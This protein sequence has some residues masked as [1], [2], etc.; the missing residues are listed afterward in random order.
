MIENINPTDK[1]VVDVSMYQI[2]INASKLQSLR[3]EVATKYNVPI[4]N[5]YINPK[6]I[7][8]DE[9]G[10]PVSLTSDIITSI[11][12]PKF[13][14]NLF[15]EYI[16]I[17]KIENVDMDMILDIDNRVNAFV[18]FDSYSKYKSYKFK[19]VKWKNFLSYGDDNYIDF[20]KLHGLVLLCGNP[21]NQS[22]KTTLARNLL[23]FALF[24][25]SEKT[26]NLASVFNEF[27][28]EETEMRVEV[29]IEIEGE[30]YVIRRT[31]TRPAFSKRTAKSKCKQTVDYYKVIDNELEL[32]ENCEAESTQ[33]TNNIIRDS[34]GSLEDFDLIVSATAKTL[35]DLF[36]MG[37][38]DQGKLFSRWLGLL[39]LEKKENIAKDIYKKNVEPTLLSNKYNRVTLETEITDMK[40]VIKD[41]D[42]TISKLEKDVEDKNKEL[43]SLNDD[44][45]KIMSERKEVKETLIKT[46]VTTVENNIAFISDKLTNERAKFAKQ[47]EEWAQVKDVT[48]DVEEHKTKQHEKIEL[49]TQN[50]AIKQ[51]ILLIRQNIQHINEL[52]EQKV[53]PNCGHEVDVNSQTEIIDKENNK[54][55]QLIQNGVENK[56]KIDALD[57]EILVLEENR[58]K[59]NS[60]NKLKLSMTALHTQIENYKLQIESL[61][62]TKQEIETNR[63]NILHNNEIDNKIRIV[64]ENIRTIT[65]AKETHI[66]T[67]QSCK[68]ENTRYTKEINARNELITKLVEEEKIIRSWNIY[69]ELIGKNGI[70]K[71]VLKRALPIINNEISTLLNGLV[72]FDVVLSV[73]D[74]NKV[75]IDLVHDGVSMSVGRAASGYEETMASLALR[76]A[77][78]TVSSFAKPNLLVLDEIFGATGSSHYDDIR[79]LLNRIMKNHDFVIDI[80]HNEMIT[81]WHNQII[82]VI[83]ENNISRI[84]VK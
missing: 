48:F 43:K 14:Q 80:T 49:A 21:Q 84:V 70:L 65:N 38:T 25:R 36:S 7:S 20:T 1:I 47:K 74:D 54:I 17:K 6:P 57:K 27:L 37:Q 26:P 5:V 72:D 34:I 9:N 73:S 67:I 42:A 41:N 58:E 81:D 69:K 63:D 77:L 35:G 4:K 10:K 52:I 39:S 78:A 8:V 60:A 13:Q 3:R 23:R 24:G 46:D 16:D 44:K 53:C 29:G 83:K 19:Y 76:S 51:E 79:E 18:D 28:P 22:G 45:V 55:E 12:D 15:K 59:V 75:C 68:D 82:E 61:N 2:D 62:K 64:D 30:D 40:T 32:I 66:R 50:G 56:K 31:V 11:Q 33:Q 71:I